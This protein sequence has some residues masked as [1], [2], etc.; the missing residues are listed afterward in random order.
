MGEKVF[1]HV[2]LKVRTHKVADI[3]H[4]IVRRGIDNAEDKIDS[5]NFKDHLY[6]KGA[7]VFRCGVG[8]GPYDH[9]EYDI[10]DS[11]KHRAEKVKNQ[12]G[13]IGFVIGKE[14]A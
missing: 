6:C 7:N 11:G 2:R 8:D 12:R 1:S 14:A 13:H 4:K 9:R 10:A 3:Y 5:G